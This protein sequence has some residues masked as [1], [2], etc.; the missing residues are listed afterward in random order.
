MP[1]ER[2]FAQVCPYEEKETETDEEK[3]TAPFTSR[4]GRTEAPYAPPVAEYGAPP[5]PELITHAVEAIPLTI[6][7]INAITPAETLPVTHIRSDSGAFS[8]SF[9][10]SEGS[11]FQEEGSIKNLPNSGIVLVKKGSFSYT[12]PDGVPVKLSYVA[13]ENGFQPVGDHLP[14]ARY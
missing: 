1:E 3:A 10:D 9:A 8:V 5:P 14:V 7:R 11:T 12:G 13:D 2:R 6:A 4:R